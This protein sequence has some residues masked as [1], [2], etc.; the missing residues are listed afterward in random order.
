M[1]VGVAQS[2]TRKGNETSLK[3][4]STLEKASRHE[5]DKSK[6]QKA[7]S[8]CEPPIKTN[9][10]KSNANDRCHSEI[11]ASDPAAGSCADSDGADESQKHQ[12]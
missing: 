6:P 11:M 2:R 4:A 5:M 10:P 8:E 9:I 12:R 1:P 7:V 3:S